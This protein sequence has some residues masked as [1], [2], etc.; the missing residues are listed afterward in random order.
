[1]QWNHAGRSCFG[2]VDWPMGVVSEQMNL[3]SCDAFDGHLPLWH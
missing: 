3:V 1:M 2:A